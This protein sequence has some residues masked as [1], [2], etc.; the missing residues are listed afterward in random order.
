MNIKGVV[1]KIGV[2]EIDTE[3]EREREQERQGE[4]ERETVE[5]CKKEI[6]KPRKCSIPSCLSLTLR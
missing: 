6:N 5:K 4:R 1:G 3:R 2:R